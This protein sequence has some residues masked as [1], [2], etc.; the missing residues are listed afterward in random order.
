MWRILGALILG[1]SICL[2]GI[3]S[4]RADDQRATIKGGI[5]G[6]VKAVDV[7]GKTLT[8]TTLQGRE[9]TF[10]ITADTLMRGPRGGKVRRH[11]KDPRFREGFTVTIVADGNTATEVHLGFARGGAAA[12]GE[13]ASTRTEESGTTESNK[14]TVRS[15]VSKKISPTAE[16]T[17]ETPKTA[18]RKKEDT[19][20]EEDD[21]HE[22]PGHVSRF[23]V[24]RR[25][26]VVRLLNGKNR[27]F[28]LSRDVPVHIE[29][30]AAASAQGLK[31]PQLKAGAQVTV[32]TDE[33]GRKVKEL[34]IVPASKARRKRA[35]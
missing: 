12:I 28:L 4:T 3:S 15:R 29:G 7:A 33:G 23:D 20:L 8:I 9:R 19:K 14:P 10:T 17:A 30:V 22:I 34:I 24:A 21:E 18:A 5:E 1:A 2:V 25:I 6:K 35:G 27:S 11:L 26:L 32:V 16:D 31:D 13:P